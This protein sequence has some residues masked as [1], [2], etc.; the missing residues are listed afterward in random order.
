MLYAERI[1]RL[2]SIRDALA[3]GQ[4][5]ESLTVREFISWFNAE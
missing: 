5:V 3:T 4:P 2:T 1:R